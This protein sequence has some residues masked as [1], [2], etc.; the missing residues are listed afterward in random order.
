MS[1]TISVDQWEKLRSEDRGQYWRLAV[2]GLVDQPLTGL[3]YAD[4]TALPM[5]RQVLTMQ[6]IGNWIWR[7]IGGQ[8]RVGRHAA[9]QRARHGRDQERGDPSQVYSA[10]SDGYTTS[11]P[12]DPRTARRG[13]PRLGNEWRAAA[14]QARVSLALDKSRH[15]GQKMPKW[16]TRIELIDEEYL[17]YWEASPRTS[18]SSGRTRPWR[19]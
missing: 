15:Y 16:I 11:I 7:A 19:P 4:I 10:S 6:C 17:G 2:D 18:P 1:G 3:T 13:D 14:L 5:Q 9:V 12:L 8:C